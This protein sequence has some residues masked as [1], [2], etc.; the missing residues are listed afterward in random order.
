MLM[1]DML[2]AGGPKG[3]HYGEAMA[4]Y[5]KLLATSSDLQQAI[6][7]SLMMPSACSILL[8]SA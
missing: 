2:V 5:S 8:S 3:G 1:R 6:A 4:I 7:A